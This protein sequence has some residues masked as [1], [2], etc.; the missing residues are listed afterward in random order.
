MTIK[1]IKRGTPPEEVIYHGTCHRCG[2]EIEFQRKDAKF[3]GDQRDGWY[4][5]VACPVC[6]GIISVAE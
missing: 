5:K 3:D 4:L 1:I 2:T 6:T